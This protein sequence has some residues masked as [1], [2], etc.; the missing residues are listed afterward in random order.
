MHQLLVSSHN[1]W[2]GLNLM[3]GKISANR[4][5]IYCEHFWESDAEK[6]C[7]LDPIQQILYKYR[8]W[9]ELLF[10]LVCLSS[11]YNHTFCHYI[12]SH[13]VKFSV[14]AIVACI[15]IW[16]GVS[17]L[18]NYCENQIVYGTCQNFFLNVVLLTYSTTESKWWVYW[19]GKTSRNSA[20]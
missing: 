19:S 17:T 16:P 1:M 8:V 7:E 3:R 6:S 13:F 10:L 11:L 20:R 15:F 18:Y 2:Y 9:N 5:E 4:A 14:S 12:S